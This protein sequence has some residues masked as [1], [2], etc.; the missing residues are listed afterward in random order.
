MLK[1]VGNDRWQE[2]ARLGGVRASQIRDAFDNRLYA[3]FCYVGLALSP[4]RPLSCYDEDDSLHLRRSPLRHYGR[5]Y[6]DG[7]YDLVGCPFEVR[8]TNVFI[9]Q[10]AGPQQL[11][12]A[13]PDNLGFD[14]FVE[15]GNNPI[16]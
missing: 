15:R 12:M 11:K 1:L 7:T 3:T 6:L 5:V 2:L 13:Q 4:D 8:C 16:R 10:L 9:Y 14:G